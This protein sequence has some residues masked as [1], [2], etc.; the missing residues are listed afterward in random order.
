MKR[1]LTAGCLILLGI[2]AAVAADDQN[3]TDKA[4]AE[5]P[6]TSQ[7]G[8]TSEPT[9]KPDAASLS[10]KQ[11]QSEPGVNSNS[12]TTANPTGVPNDSSLSKGQKDSSGQN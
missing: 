9:A 6:G 1:I 7:P 8:A 4:K 5:H 12:G 3:I 11:K 2:S 10:A